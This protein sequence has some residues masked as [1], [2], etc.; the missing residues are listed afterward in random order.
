[1]DRCPSF[2][3]FVCLVLCVV[4]EFKGCLCANA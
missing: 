4:L 2:V 1:M 3:F